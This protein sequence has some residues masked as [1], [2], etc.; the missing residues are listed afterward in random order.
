MFEVILNAP[1]EEY[2]RI[3][4]GHCIPHRELSSR[5]KPGSYRDGELHPFQDALD[6]LGMSGLFDE[7]LF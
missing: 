1:L 4:W 6:L 5:S 3:V 7:N 2:G